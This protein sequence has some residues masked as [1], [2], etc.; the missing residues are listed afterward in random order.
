M[1]QHFA[2][3]KMSRCMTWSRRE[4]GP[5]SGF[6]GAFEMVQFLQAES[7]KDKVKLTLK[8]VT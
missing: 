6:T 3:Q 5:Y 4:L 1:F 7:L 2:L 8:D